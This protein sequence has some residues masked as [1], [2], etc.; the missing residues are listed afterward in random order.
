MKKKLSLS[1]LALSATTL[2]ACGGQKIDF[3]QAQYWQRTN[4]SEAI[5]QR[6]PK[7]QQMVQRDISRCVSELHELER[8]GYIKHAFPEP[9]TRPNLKDEEIRLKKWETPERDG[10]LLN[11]VSVY[12]DFEECMDARGWERVA[13]LP[14]KTKVRAEENYLN[15]LYDAQHKKRSGTQAETNYQGFGQDK[16]PKDKQMGDPDYQ[17]LND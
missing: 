14:Y 4:T 10:Y 8:I 2:V 17:N 13:Y 1:L 6:G 16:L 9:N 11:E 5:Y 15:A 7:A 3:T 12:Y